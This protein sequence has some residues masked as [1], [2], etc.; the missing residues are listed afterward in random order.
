[1]TFETNDNYSIRF[2]ISNNSSAI[3]FD[4]KWKKHYS[5]S[6]TWKDDRVTGHSDKP[7]RSQLVEIIIIYKDAN[8]IF[9]CSFC[10]HP[11]DQHSQTYT[12]TALPVNAKTNTVTDVTCSTVFNL[13]V[14][15]LCLWNFT[16]HHDNLHVFNNNNNNNNANLVMLLNE[17]KFRNNVKQKVS[18]ISYYADSCD[19]WQ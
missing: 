14:V 7:A 18:N 5:H 8:G 12:L 13:L 9:R 6:T 10:T 4:S 3:R 17:R 15:L 2:K 16:S 11:G 1:V 19:Y